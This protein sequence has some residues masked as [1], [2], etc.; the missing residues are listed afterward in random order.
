MQ[1]LN[2]NGKTY[3]K[4]YLTE[5]DVKNRNQRIYPFDIAKKA[6]RE[7]KER[8]DA[9][10]VYS[11][12]GHPSHSDTIHENSCG[13]IVEV[14]WEDDTGRATCKVEILDDTIDGKKVLQMIKEKKNLGISTRGLGSLDENG[15]VKEGLVFT[16]ADIIESNFQGEYGQSCQVC[17]MNLSESTRTNTMSDFLESIDGIDN[18]GCFLDLN[19]LEQKVVYENLKQKI[20]EIFKKD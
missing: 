10:G 6:V 4:G 20:I 5:A 9:N 8:V 13:K 19:E 3:L 18:C 7:L 14:L 16:T 2:E 15:N 11:Y 12:L 17:T 1:I